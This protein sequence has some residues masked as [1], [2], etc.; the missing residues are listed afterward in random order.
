MGVENGLGLA[1]H[2]ERALE[3]DPR[4]LLLFVVGDE[5]ETLA[6]TDDRSRHKSSTGYN[7][8]QQVVS[9]VDSDPDL[10]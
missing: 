4:T 10:I 1:L 8:N 2:T 6:D 9:N 3:T 5:H 7:L